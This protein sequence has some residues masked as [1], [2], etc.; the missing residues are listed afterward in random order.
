[1]ETHEG[2]WNL[3][4]E[5]ELRI[6]VRVRDSGDVVCSLNR[7][8]SSIER[9]CASRGNELFDPVLICDHILTEVSDPS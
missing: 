2:H 8:M 1:M 7:S 4:R 3:V 6:T 5:R 9:Y